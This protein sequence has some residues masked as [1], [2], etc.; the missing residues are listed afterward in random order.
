MNSF[1]SFV[2][3][4]AAVVLLASGASLASGQARSEK[5]VRDL[6]RSI[7]SQVDDFQ[8]KLDYQL[9]SSSADRRVADDARMGLSNLQDKMSD[10]QQNFDR[11][12]ENR[13]DVNDVVTAAK[14]VEGFLRA[15]PQNKSIDD[16]WNRIKDLIN[17]L[18][19][20]YGVTPDWSGRISNARRSLETG[21]RDHLPRRRAADGRPDR[22]CR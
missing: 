6:I 11:R 1:R 22:L 17:Q 18:A 9:T 5:Q 3:V 20:N 2:A 15:N 21:G 19:A 4:I 10:F 8:Y 13:S 12:R 16:S 14:D 7:N